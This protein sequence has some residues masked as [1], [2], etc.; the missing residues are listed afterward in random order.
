[1]V[2]QF[3]NDEENRLYKIMGIYIKQKATKDIRI[4]HTIIL[5]HDFIIRLSYYHIIT[6][7]FFYNVK[8]D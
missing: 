7:L 4:I 5:T 1:M 2:Q 8:L 6:C 3:V